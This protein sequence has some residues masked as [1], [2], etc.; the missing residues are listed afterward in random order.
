MQTR[1]HKMLAE[2]LLSEMAW[3]IPKVYM[4]DICRGILAPEQQTMRMIAV[5]FWR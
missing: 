1:D 5:I 2:F 3:D 4:R